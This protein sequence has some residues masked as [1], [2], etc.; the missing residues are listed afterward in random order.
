MSHIISTHISLANVRQ[1][2]QAEDNV[3]RKYNV[4]AAMCLVGGWGGLVLKQD[5]SLPQR[6]SVAVFSY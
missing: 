2:V 5:S 6:L 4:L 3:I 1:M